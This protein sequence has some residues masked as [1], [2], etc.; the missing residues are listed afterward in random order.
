MATREEVQ[1]LMNLW[2]TLPAGTVLQLQ[3]LKFSKKSSKGGDWE[4][5]SEISLK[6]S[7]SDYRLQPPAVSGPL[8]NN[9]ADIELLARYGS[10]LEE[11]ATG[12]LLAVAGIS[13]H[14]DTISVLIH[15]ANRGTRARWFT[16]AEL[17]AK[18]VW[19]S[20]ESR[21]NWSCDDDDEDDGE[22]MIVAGQPVGSY[23]T[24]PPPSTCR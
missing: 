14:G 1:Q 2:E 4:P 15:G 11:V 3:R 23:G 21:P 8:R 9:A 18:F 12:N 6:R 24:L 17:H 19:P 20:V 22:P 7:I 16:A 10:R 5:A 13:R